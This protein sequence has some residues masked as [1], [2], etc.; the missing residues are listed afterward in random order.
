M[1]A[2]SGLW[3][4]A[5]PSSSVT[6][7]AVER[8]RELPAWKRV[9]ALISWTP[10]APGDELCGFFGGQTVRTGQYGEYT[11]VL[12][13]VPDVGSYTVTGTEL[14]RLVN[15]ARLQDGEPVRIVFRGRERTSSDREIKRFDLLVLAS[16][17]KGGKTPPCAGAVLRECV[18]L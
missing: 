18:E 1:N 12:V 5:C 17:K 3:R 14:V 8:L 9:R 4:S 13:H 10:R 6:S 11:V 2:T 16:E 7:D 15:A